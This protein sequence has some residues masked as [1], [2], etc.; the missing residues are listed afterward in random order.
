MKIKIETENCDFDNHYLIEKSTD[1]KVILNIEMTKIASLQSRKEIRDQITSLI[2][3]ELSKFKWIISGSVV[4][5][6]AWYLNA[7]ERQETDKIGD[8][9][10]ISKPIQDSLTGSNGILID[11]AQIRG[12][13]SF[14]MSRNELIS[15]NIL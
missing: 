15:D 8:I 14:W 5:E 11:D 3:N 4:V 2:K 13:Y 6:F 12:L 9:D 7:I 1:G 10:N